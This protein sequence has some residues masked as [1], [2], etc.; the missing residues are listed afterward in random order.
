MTSSRDARAAFRHSRA[1]GGRPRSGATFACLKVL[2]NVS[3]ESKG[4]WIPAKIQAV[5]R[6][7]AEI[8]ND[9]SWLWSDRRSQVA[10]SLLHVSGKKCPF[11]KP[12]KGILRAQF[13][14][15]RLVE[16]CQGDSRPANGEYA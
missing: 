5:A 14:Q 13:C 4:R 12:I 11:H 6:R 2:S 16:G 8:E 1:P 7:I 3:N 15:R 10:C 9:H